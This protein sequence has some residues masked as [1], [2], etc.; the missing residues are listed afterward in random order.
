MVSLVLIALLAGSFVYLFLSIVAAFRYLQAR[1]PV[2]RSME[3]ISIL[4]PLA[5]LDEGLES[6]LRTFFE[7]DYPLFEILFAVREENDRAVA[8]V[9]KLQRE[10]PHIPSRLLIAGESSYPNAKV[11]SLSQMLAVAANDLV[12]ASDSDIRVGRD[13]L[14]KIAAE[15]QNPDL[16]VATCPYRTVPGHS[17]WSC[18]EATGLNTDFIAGILVARMLEGMK[19]AVGATIAVRRTALEAIGGFDRLKDYLA[20]DF[21]MGKFAAEAHYHVILSSH[22]V[23][24][25]IGNTSLCQNVSHRLRWLRSTRRSRPAGYIGQ[26]F[27]MPF[28]LALLVCFANRSLWPVLLLTLLLRAFAAYIMSARVLHTKINWILLIFEDLVGFCFWIAG[29]FGNTIVWRERRYRLKPDGRFEF[30]GTEQI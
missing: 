25:R 26:L 8:V 28:P 2:L 7:Q 1:P 24:H 21:V 23:E 13:L 30:L 3:P 29:F 4:K 15:F 27:T 10:F 18:L 22:V 16:G 12:V 20:D 14:R 6:N 5:G 11:F 9:Q 17:I 19:F